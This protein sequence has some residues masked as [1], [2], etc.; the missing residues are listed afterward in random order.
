[1]K[2]MKIISLAVVQLALFIPCVFGQAD[3]FPIFDFKASVKIY[4]EAQ[5]KVVSF[6]VQSYFVAHEGL[7]CEVFYG[8][9]GSGKWYSIYSPSADWAYIR[10]LDE[11]GNASFGFDDRKV[12]GYGKMTFNKTTGS[13]SS[14]SIMGT[15]TDLDDQ[16]GTFT[17]KYNSTLT[18]K[19]ITSNL[20]SLD[21]VVASLTAKGYVLDD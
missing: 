15:I 3:S 9:T 4:D 13:M 8:G 10:V 17:L 7:T 18:N 2:A 5:L 14:C 6:T 12:F 21:M 1:M 20:S 16:T 11:K 19:A